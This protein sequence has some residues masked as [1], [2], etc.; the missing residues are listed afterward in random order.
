MVRLE[1]IKPARQVFYC[2]VMCYKG[3]GNDGMIVIDKII[4]Y[5]GN[6]FSEATDRRSS[7]LGFHCTNI[8]LAFLLK[9][10]VLI[11][12]FLCSTAS[13]TRIS[14]SRLIGAGRLWLI[15]GLSSN[16]VRCISNSV[17]SQS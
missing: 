10:N 5:K 16:G 4:C 7:P 2:R 9:C 8:G 11:M 13:L 1:T 14:S 12:P 15:A 6:Y 3:H 17:F